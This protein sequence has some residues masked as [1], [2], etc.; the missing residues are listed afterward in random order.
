MM[1]NDPIEQMR[2]NYRQLAT[3]HQAGQLSWEQ[4][5]ARVG[6]LQ[7][8]DQYGVPWS[9]D[10]RDGSML[11]YDGSQ[12]LPD[13]PPP[14]SAAQRPSAASPTPG[15]SV[16]SLEKVAGTPKALRPTMQ[17]LHARAIAMPLLAL[18]PSMACGGLWFLYTFL[19]IFKSEGL[20]GID[21]LT[22]IIVVGVPMVFWFYKK[23]LDKLLAPL[24]PIIGSIPTPLRFGIIF[25][26]PMTLS[27][28][29]SSVD[30]SG[31]GALRFSSLVS[32][33]I[34]TILTR[35]TEVRP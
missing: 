10:P 1:T 11:R 5:V 13:T 23:P 18:V 24:D 6:Q 32:I 28:I 22:P 35:K 17:R 2:T 14:Q 4:F 31:Y 27:C 16:A 8:K 20:Q 21:F 12:W 29:C 3:Q 26:V 9:I 33:L 34:A 15:S 30:S 19:G 7:A 25:G